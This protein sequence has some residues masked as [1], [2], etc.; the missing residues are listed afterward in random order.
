MALAATSL[1]SAGAAAGATRNTN[2]GLCWY[3]TDNNME[4]TE[5]IIRYQLE[6]SPLFV[7]ED[8]QPVFGCNLI[9]IRG[10]K[11]A[12]YNGRIGY[13]VC[14]D[15]KSTGRYGIKF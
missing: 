14:P 12:T 2:L 13:I 10:K 3:P 4:R 1:I 11:T 9:E 6:E 7:D 5:E 8:D 15:P